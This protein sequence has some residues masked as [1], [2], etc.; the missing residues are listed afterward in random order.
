MPIFSI[1]SQLSSW[2]QQWPI[3]R[4]FLVPALSIGSN[5]SVVLIL[6][7]N[8]SYAIDR[9][10][11]SVH[12]LL[13]VLLKIIYLEFWAHCP[14]YAIWHCRIVHATFVV[15]FRFGNV[16]VKPERRRASRV[17]IVYGTFGSRRSEFLSMHLRL[18]GNGVSLQYRASRLPFFISLRH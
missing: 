4:W 13:V 3:F 12:L 9:I 1:K 11:I 6:I 15:V 7:D 16:C 18:S 17:S 10:V 2:S 8:S 5:Q 14:L